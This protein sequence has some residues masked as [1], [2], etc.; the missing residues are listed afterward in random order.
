MGDQAPR[1]RSTFRTV[2]FAG[3]ALLLSF[4]LIELAC[5]VVLYEPD[6]PYSLGLVKAFYMFQ[7]IT[8]DT[9]SV[10]MIFD[11]DAT[12]IPP[13]YRPDPLVGYT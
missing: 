5:R 6:S 3:V 8:F 10:E 12:P 1:G 11:P 4:G 2:L 7:A 13:A 9:T